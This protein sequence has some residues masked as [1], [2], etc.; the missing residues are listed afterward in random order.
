MRSDVMLLIPFQP[1]AGTFMDQ[2]ARRSGI[3]HVNLPILEARYAL[4]AHL[5]RE[6]APTPASDRNT[7][8]RAAV[9]HQ[10]HRSASAVVLSTH[11][12]RAG[13]VWE[14][15]DPGARDLSYWRA[16]LHRARACPPRT[17]AIC[18]TFVVSAPWLRLLCALVRRALPDARLLV[19]GYYYA[20]S[21]KDFLSLDAD[22]LCVGE[23]EERLPRIV[24]AIRRND[25]AEL[26]RI[27]GLYV[28]DGA[29]HMRFTGAVQ[30]L[31]LDALPAPDWRLVE[32]IEPPARIDRDAIVYLVETQRGCVFKCEFCTYRTLANLTRASAEC[33]VRRITGVAP[34]EASARSLV[35]IVDSTATYPHDRWRAILGLLVAQ[36]GSRLPISVYARVSDI[37]EDIAGLMARAGVRRAYIGQESGDQELLN[38]MKKGTRVTQVRPA[39]R[40]LWRHRIDPLVAFIHGFPGESERSLSATRELLATLND[41]A[42]SEPACTFYRIEPFGLQDCAS[43]SQAP[44]IVEGEHYLGY[45]SGLGVERVM[46]EVLRTV[47]H[48]SR[49]ATAPV[50]ESALD[51]MGFPT[52]S[53]KDRLV[54]ADRRQAF[55]WMKAVERGVA[56]FIERGLDGTRPD[57]A[58]LARTSRAILDGL[59]ESSPVRQLRVRV[60]SA[61]MARA[62]RR[63]RQECSAEARRGIGPLTR[64]LLAGMRLRDT[65]D[66]R[67]LITGSFEMGIAPLRSAEIDALASALVSSALGSKKGDPGT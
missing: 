47:V 26:E 64:A 27:P 59:D 11:L 38:R 60:R 58:E 7:V 55:R 8:T 19:G 1:G 14:T 66:L 17:V 41:G 62:A 22:V 28:R 12:E 56:I 32:R 39:V 63:L 33:A 45:S 48:A 20:T 31:D 53:V 40:A 24:H 57:R 4:E 6:L 23:G 5:G 65:G 67:A 34:P 51:W 16:R 49:V 36:G 44:G 29:G 18:S 61:A 13:L 42:D 43:I 25:W 3:A 52:G 37:T 30:A 15:I 9:E 35:D 54:S 2:E 46:V 10:A 21:A 50:C